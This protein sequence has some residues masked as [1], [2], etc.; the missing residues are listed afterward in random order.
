MDL[1][2]L[3]QKSQE[4][5]QEAQSLAL[6]AG[7]MEVDS[8]HLLLALLEQAD[9]LVPRLLARIDVQAESLKEHLQREL[10]RRPQVSGA[11]REA[12]KIYI[13]QRLQQLHWVDAIFDA[14][15][16]NS[17]LTLLLFFNIFHRVCLT[18]PTGE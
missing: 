11:G 4:A 13:T 6:R 15:L 3:T 16:M 9:G 18:L 8:D 14:F 10:Q 1:N 12:D 5:L 7:H 2:K 17:A